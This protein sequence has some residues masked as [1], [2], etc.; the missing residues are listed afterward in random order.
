MI[1]VSFAEVLS[2]GAVLPFLGALT[3]PQHIFDL[4]LSQPLIRFLGVVSPSHLLLLIT[5]I[6]GIAA[7]VAGVLRLLLLW[8]SLSFSYGVGADISS[9]IYRRTLYQPYAVHV[10]RNSSEIIN[11]ILG[12]TGAVIGV[13]SSVL[14][15]LGSSFILTTI[16]IALFLIDPVTAFSAFFGFGFIYLVIIRLTKQR[17]LSNGRLIARESTELVKSLQEGLGSIRDILIDGTQ[18]IYCHTYR[19]AD[20]Q[21]RRA[22][23]SSQFI[24]QSPRYGIEAIGMVLISGLAFSASLES[25]G[26]AGVI[27]VLGALALGAQRLLPVLQ[28]AY[29]SWSAIQGQQASLSDALYLLDQPLPDFAEEPP[30]KPTRFLKEIQLNGLGFRY[31]SE[32]P[33]ILKNLNLTI[34]KGSRVGFVGETGS[35]KSTLID[36]IMGLLDPTQGEI[37]VDGRCITHKNSRTW[38]ARIAHVPQNIFLSDGSIEENIAFGVPKD[39]IDFERVKHAAT[40]AQIANTIESWELQYKTVVGERGIRL[41]GGQRQRI[42]IA[43]AFY[44]EADVIIF[45]EATS[46][47]D[48]KTEEAVMTAIESL[49]RDLTILIIAHRITTLKNCTKIVKLGNHGIEC[50]G[51]YDEVI[52]RNA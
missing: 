43:R 14:M 19:R 2:I 16:L 32:M 38:Q 6:F 12:K 39:Q 48:S 17:Q 22:Q 5:V 30:T 37:I 7:L 46:A 24:G 47:L 40:L 10:A 20:L 51:N 41:S 18:E 9:S 35:G 3:N 15:F 50:V 29:Q 4:P 45:D 11:G 13:I 23:G 33:W 36:I 21:L 44:K 28:Q 26:I 49:K 27:P 1:I 52:L 31:N 8:T 34:S 25:E 42:G